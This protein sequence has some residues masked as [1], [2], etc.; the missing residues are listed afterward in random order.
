MI[1]VQY[2]DLFFVWGSDV[3]RGIYGPLGVMFFCRNLLSKH[4]SPGPNLS[5]YSVTF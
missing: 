1:H 2:L 3:L 4:P 5:P